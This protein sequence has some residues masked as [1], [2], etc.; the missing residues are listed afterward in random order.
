MQRDAVTRCRYK[1]CLFSEYHVKW[2]TPAALYAL[3]VSTHMV[4]PQL[5][6]AA[7]LMSDL[8]CEGMLTAINFGGFFK[9][10]HVHAASC[11]R[12]SVRPVIIIIV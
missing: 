3:P 5:S 6:A 12:F 10:Y 8:Q 7:S 11:M 4:T 1:T 9:G 2:H